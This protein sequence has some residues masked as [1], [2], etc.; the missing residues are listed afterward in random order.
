VK[1]AIS[2]IALCA[3]LIFFA[4]CGTK[5]SSP[6]IMDK[7]APQA[8]AA[9][10]TAAKKNIALVMKTLTNPFFVEMEKG[11]RRAEKEFNINL[12]VKSGAKETSIDQQIAI[13]DE[14][15]KAKVD[16]IVIAPGDSRELI[17]V[18]KRAQDA[19]IV[20]INIDNRLEQE[21][22]AKIGLKAPFISV[23]NEQGAYLSAKFISDKIKTPTEV[24][25]LEGIRAAKN[26]DDRKRGA[27]RAFKENSNIRIV[28][29]ESANWKIDEANEVTARLFAD[30]PKIGAMFCANDMMAFG[31]I[32]YLE[33]SGRQGV[34]VAGFDALDEAKKAIRSGKMSVTI[35]QQA[36]AQGY[37]G[38]QSAI[39]VLK[40]E[41]VSAETMVD[42]K[43][44][45][46]GNL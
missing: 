39:K 27:L 16:A 14:L 2:C 19:K 46:A 30:F 7:N 22:A 45:H 6:L 20:I 21:M 43:V 8:P 18:L 17:P 40:G 13:V 28:A 12:I 32:E 44:I 34:L 29:M 42:V 24:A 4:G 37:I 23:D 33:K 11:A 26:A 15:I 25:I 9:G 36:E 31:A 38:V 10:Q 1:K 3:C 5:E 41:Q 35:D